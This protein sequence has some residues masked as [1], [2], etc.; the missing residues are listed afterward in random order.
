MSFGIEQIAFTLDMIGK[1]LI[2]IAVI[3]VHSRVGRE[4]KIDS[5]VLKSIKNEMWWTYI[6]IVFLTAG[7]VMHVFY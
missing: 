7:W 1:I 3:R 6:G 2:G 5:R 4:R